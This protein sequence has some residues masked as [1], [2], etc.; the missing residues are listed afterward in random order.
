MIIDHVPLYGAM[1]K[2]SIK[3]GMSRQN[4]D[5]SHQLSVSGQGILICFEQFVF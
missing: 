1:K 5:A 3:A 2:L 4:E